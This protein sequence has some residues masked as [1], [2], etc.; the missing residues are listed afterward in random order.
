MNIFEEYKDTVS[1][2]YN[3]I[4]RITR[5]AFAKHLAL[6]GQGYVPCIRKLFRSISMFLHYN[7]YMQSNAFNDD[8]FSEPPLELSNRKVKGQFSN[9]AG[10]FLYHP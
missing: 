1:E 9:L 3:Q 7:H 10:R 2:I 8:R 5:M 6:F 4:H